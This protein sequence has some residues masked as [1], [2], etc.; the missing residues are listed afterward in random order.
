MFWRKAP[1]GTSCL[2]RFFYLSLVLSK[3]PPHPPTS[4]NLG[5]VCTSK[6]LTDWLA[7]WLINCWGQK[8]CV[9]SWVQKHSIYY[10]D[11]KLLIKSI[12][13]SEHLLHLCWLW[14]P[15]S[16]IPDHI[17]PRLRTGFHLRFFKLSWLNDFPDLSWAVFIFFPHVIS[18]QFVACAWIFIQIFNSYWEKLGPMHAACFLQKLL[19]VQQSY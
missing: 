6:K 17:F 3:K 18:S 13:T 8:L 14:N 2:I 19:K 4:Y 10:Q 11:K 12:C 16:S 9:C 15:D 1:T 7:T 5:S